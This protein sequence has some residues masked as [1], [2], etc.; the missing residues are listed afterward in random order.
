LVEGEKKTIFL[1]QVDEIVMEF[2]KKKLLNFQQDSFFVSIQFQISSVEL[3]GIDN[4][5]KLKK[6]VWVNSLTFRSVFWQIS[7]K[8]TQYLIGES[9]L[10][11]DLNA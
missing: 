7:K 1:F 5:V 6:T 2:E 3:L 4:Q 9:L 10:Q 8:K 11:T